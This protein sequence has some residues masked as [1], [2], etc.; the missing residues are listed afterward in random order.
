VN[1]TILDNSI[2]ILFKGDENEEAALLA[3]MIQNG[4]M[5]YSFTREDSD[6]EALFMQIT[7]K[8]D[9]YFI[10]FYY[11]LY[12]K[13][14]NWLYIYYI[15]YSADRQPLANSSLYFEKR[16]DRGEFVSSFTWY[17]HEKRRTLAFFRFKPHPSI[18]M[19]GNYSPGHIDPQ[20]STLFSLGG[21]HF[22]E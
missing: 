2:S 10:A 13:L 18:E 5:L 9:S 15:P 11:I 3:N 21:D 8:E 20:A 19:S 14:R 22:I 17:F 4:V 6:L 7:N 16:G 12:N 1:V